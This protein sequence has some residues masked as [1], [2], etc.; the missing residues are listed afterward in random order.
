M[1][2]SLDEYVSFLLRALP[3][4]PAE[5]TI[6]RLWATAHPGLLV[7]PRWNIL[8][9][10]LSEILRQKMAEAGLRQGQSAKGDRP[11]RTLHI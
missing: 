4:I 1:L 7:A 10:N 11:Q 8:A 5:V 3:V 6:H 2:F 9:S